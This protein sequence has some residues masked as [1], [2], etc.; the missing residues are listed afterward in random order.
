MGKVRAGRCGWIGSLI[1]NAKHVTKESFMNNSNQPFWKDEPEASFLH[2]PSKQAAK[3]YSFYFTTA[4]RGIV[5]IVVAIML[6]KSPVSMLIWLFI[7]GLPLGFRIYL[8]FRVK[9]DV[10]NT[11]DI[12]KAAMEKIGATH[13]GSAIHVAGH[14][15]LQRDQSVVLALVDDQLNIFN[16]E[17]STP[18]DSIPLGNIRTLHTVSY[19]DERVPHVDAIDS[20]AQALQLTLLWRDQ[21]CTCLF[22]RM[23]KMK[24]IDWYQAIQQVRLQSNLAK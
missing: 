20:V 7:F 9:N 18:L 22:R 19:D 13:I 10:Q 14:P 21:P 23:R 6:Y 12:Q 16:Y 17:N 24:P 3:P 4:I 2:Y 1:G 8:L 15:L 5:L 11:D